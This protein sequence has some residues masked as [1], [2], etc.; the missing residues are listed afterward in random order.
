[1]PLH[2]QAPSEDAVWEDGKWLPLIDVHDNDQD[3]PL[4]NLDHP[5][6]VVPQTHAKRA[7]VFEA[8]LLNAQKHLKLTGRHLDIYPDIAELYATL[9]HG[10]TFA[11]SDTPGAEGRLGDDH[12]TVKVIAPTNTTET[13]TLNMADNFSHLLV[14][15]ITPGFHVT[16]RM[17]ARK[18]LPGTSDQMRKI[19]WSALPQG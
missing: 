9:A 8:L 5:A 14:V 10:F 13:V 17:V 19:R 11:R 16:S 7:A 15:R 12:Y 2:P 4:I 3:S 6:P 1:M 18:D